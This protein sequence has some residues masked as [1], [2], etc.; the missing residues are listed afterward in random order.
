MQNQPFKA[1][2]TPEGAIDISHYARQAAAERRA[3]KSRVMRRIGRGT[4]RAVLAI[5]GF[6]AFWNIPPMGSGGPK[7]TPYR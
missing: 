2:R 6:V 4:R 1:P 5:I 7:D 3:T